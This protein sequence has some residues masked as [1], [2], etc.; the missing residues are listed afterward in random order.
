MRFALAALLVLTAAAPSLAATGAVQLSS[1]P[2]TPLDQAA[3]AL[4]AHDIAQSVAHGEQPLV[5]VGSAKLS[6]ARGAPPALFVQLQS[7]ALCGSAGCDT[8]VYLDH[9]GRWTK[10]LDSVSGPIRVL[11]RW[12]GH[13]HDVMVGENDRWTWAGHA[14]QDTMTAPALT[15]L[16]RSVERHQAAVAKGEVPPPPK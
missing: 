1:Q 2:G 6:T 13:M 10:V 4:A 5:L 8:S 15:G 9:H 3:R 11:P 16:K 12:Q 7:A 14:Y